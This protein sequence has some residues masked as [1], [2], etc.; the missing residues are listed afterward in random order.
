M[1]AS[2]AYAFDTVFDEDGAVLREGTH[3]RLYSWEDVERERQAAHAAGRE[4]EANRAARDT[5]AA[6][7]QIAAA[8]RDIAARYGDDRRAVMADAAQLALAAARK[9]AGAALDRFGETRVS[10]AL[11]EAFDAFVSAPRVV[12]RVAPVLTEARERLEGIAR[13][14]GFDGALVVRADPA[15]RLGDVVID[16]GE[17]AI[18]HDSADAITRIETLV[19]NALAANTDTGS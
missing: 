2:R 7:A 6:L 8:A 10:A 3:G 11:E 5:A 13:D 19:A 15:V 17:G 9:A 12:L 18:A 14:H 16:W 4:D 1:T